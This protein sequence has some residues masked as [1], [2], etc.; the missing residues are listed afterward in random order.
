MMRQHEGGGNYGPLIHDWDENLEMKTDLRRR[1]AQHYS[2]KLGLT[3]DGNGLG[4]PIDC[5]AAA[6][7]QSD[8]ALLS[9]VRKK[10]DDP[11]QWI[12]AQWLDDEDWEVDTIPNSGVIVSKT[13]TILVFTR[14]NPQ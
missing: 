10:K 7:R 4:G 13:R 8:P 12:A 2:A 6:E 5:D 14:G 9:I 3:L 11:S 1:A